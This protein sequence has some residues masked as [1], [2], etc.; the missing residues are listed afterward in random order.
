MSVPRWLGFMFFP[1]SET[2][3]CVQA[4]F[5]SHI[6]MIALILKEASFM[7][8][9]LVCLG[10]LLVT[11]FDYTVASACD[12]CQPGYRGLALL[13]SGSNVLSVLLNMLAVSILSIPAFYGKV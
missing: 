1:S 3:K 7:S 5:G 6:L 10:S 11:F 12:A 9:W 13:I 8:L 2:C 4:V